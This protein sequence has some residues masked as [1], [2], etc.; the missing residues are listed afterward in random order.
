MDENINTKYAELL[1]K[2]HSAIKTDLDF[3][4]SITDASLSLDSLKSEID[5]HENTIQALGLLKEKTEKAKPNV[6]KIIKSE[7]MINLMHRL[8]TPEFTDKIIVNKK[9]DSKVAK[10]LINNINKIINSEE[11]RSFTEVHLII[12]KNIIRIIENMLKVN[13]N[14]FKSKSKKIAELEMLNKSLSLSFESFMN[15]HFVDVQNEFPKVDSSFGQSLILFDFMNNNFD[16]DFNS[17][18]SRISVMEKEEV[19]KND[20]LKEKLNLIKV[21]NDFKQMSIDSIVN[22]LMEI[23]PLIEPVKIDAQYFKVVLVDTGFI[24]S[25][26]ALIYLRS[27]Q[28]KYENRNSRFLARLSKEQHLEEEE[29]EK[30][31]S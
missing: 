10:K 5:K 2:L 19:S 22:I 30:R 20:I 26:K 9:L 6:E 4:K 28:N 27:F 11:G 24:D 31:L 23:A 14:I 8:R 25:D 18:K 1:D 16:D 15:V 29:T 13:K 7:F 12:L 17:V 21:A 3:T